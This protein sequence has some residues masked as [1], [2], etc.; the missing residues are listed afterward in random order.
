[1]YTCFPYTTLFRSGG[2]DR[3]QHLQGRAD[4]RDDQGVLD[5]GA[6]RGDL[7]GFGDVVAGEL[8]GQPLHWPGVDLRVRLECGGQLIVQR[9][10]ETQAYINQKQYTTPL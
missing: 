5:E 7:P 2:E 3:Q 1:M 6:E 8:A 9:D 4:H 10:K